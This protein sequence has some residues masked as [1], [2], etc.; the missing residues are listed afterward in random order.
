MCQRSGCTQPAAVTLSF[1]YD[2]RQASL[3]DLLPE[4]HPAVYDL[5][6]PHADIL[7]VPRG[8]ERL[9]RREPPAE[10]VITERS[11]TRVAAAPAAR[12]MDRYAA[13]TAQL[14]RLAETL[15]APASELAAEHTGPTD[16]RWPGRVSPHGGAG[17]PSAPDAWPTATRIGEP[18]HDQLLEPVTGTLLRD[19]V[20]D[21]QL[22]MPIEP[23]QHAKV[24]ALTRSR[25]L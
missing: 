15:E 22:Q 19:D 13:L 2:A 14:P 25:N 17:A 12:H 1:R 20:L 9:D 8:W 11:E 10:P 4:K 21:G 16:D 18:Q 23:E 7:V 24:V 6:D 5:C 3:V